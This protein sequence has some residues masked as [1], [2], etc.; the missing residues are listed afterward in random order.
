VDTAPVLLVTDTLLIS[1]WAD[2]TLFVTRVGFTEK[3][4]LKFA[5][6]LD[7]TGKLKSMAL[8]LNEAGFGK[9]KDYNYG[10]GYGYTS[11]ND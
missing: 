7:E 2:L 6:E 5:K 4:L 10:Y 9:S 1:D 3:R 8:V 11:E